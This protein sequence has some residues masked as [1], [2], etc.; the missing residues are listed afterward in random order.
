MELGLP[1]YHPVGMLAGTM[2]GLRGP[3]HIAGQ[4]PQVDFLI[5]ATHCPASS[6]KRSVGYERLH[7]NRPAVSNHRGRDTS[8]REGAVT[9]LKKLSRVG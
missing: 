3:D 7:R 6:V 5:S 9:S 8:G 4:G 2:T 1:R